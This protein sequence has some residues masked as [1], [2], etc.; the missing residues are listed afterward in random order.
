MKKC[1]EV[2]ID[3]MHEYLDENCSPEQEK[4]LKVHL[5][6]CEDCQQHFHELKKALALV[7]STSH[8]HAPDDFTANVMAKLPKEKK[9]IG[10]ERWFRKHPFL[11]A[12]SLFVVLMGS[13]LFSSWGNNDELVFT[14]YDGLI[15]EGQT[16]VVPEDVVMTEDLYVKNGNVIIE[17]EVKGD[18][19]VI[20]GNVINDEHEQ[21]MASAG[22]VTGEIEE[23]D[24]AFEWLWYRMKS[25]GK[26]LLSLFE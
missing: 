6:Q 10:V 16:V 12:A 20:N 26:E 4:Q 25:F 24:Q 1:P 22:N 14:K 15:V 3:Y 9:K 13:T 8:V 17:G 23:I 19:T 5:H 2:I 18:I 21:Y 11:V 7:Q